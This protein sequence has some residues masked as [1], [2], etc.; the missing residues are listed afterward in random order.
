MLSAVRRNYWWRAIKPPIARGEFVPICRELVS[1][2]GR[3]CACCRMVR[4]LWPY[5]FGP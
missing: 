5:D 4:G 1:V 2:A 3:R